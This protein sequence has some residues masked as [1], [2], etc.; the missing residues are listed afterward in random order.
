[1]SYDE[2]FDRVSKLVDE[3]VVKSAQKSVKKAQDPSDEKYNTWTEVAPDE[4]SFTR[5]LDQFLSDAIPTSPTAT[6]EAS[7]GTDKEIEDAYP[8]T[9]VST[10]SEDG[11]DNE[12]EVE[13][14]VEG[15]DVLKEGELK[16]V[17]THVLVGRFVKLA[18]EILAY[19]APHDAKVQKMVSKD[20]DIVG[21][22]TVAQVVK[23]A[24]FDADMVMGFLA[25]TAQDA[26]EAE[27]VAENLANA[28]EEAGAADPMQTGGEEVSSGDLDAAIAQLVSENPEAAAQ[29]LE[30]NPELAEALT[31][32]LSGGAAAPEADA[33]ALKEIEELVDSTT[34]QEIS[35]VI[36]QI[37]SERPD[38]AAQVVE[39]YPELAEELVM[40]IAES[41]VPGAAE[42]VEEALQEVTEE[43]PAGE[44]EEEP[45]EEKS[46][47]EQPSEEEEVKASAYAQLAALDAAME[48]LGISPQDL[49]VSVVGTPHEQDGIK[50]A[51]A[52]REFRKQ[53]A[54]KVAK[55]DP[56]LRVTFKKYLRELMFG[57]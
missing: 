3:V 5:A 10:V 51:A 22:V 41:G 11:S 55:V 12:A 4:K 16:N 18:K 36:T 45:A 27:A 9:E 48:E 26:A 17:P 34:P 37:V 53:N 30:Q 47:E 52:I 46:E 14:P 21:G 43:A 23:Q 38:V 33:A 39:Q 1:M 20:P 19:V 57:A 49:E 56:R 40:S 29:V 35:E 42:A 15:E 50:I 31:E 44:A 2:I 54:H 32:A 25:K 28:A 13:E 7:E 24:E 6:E 8:T